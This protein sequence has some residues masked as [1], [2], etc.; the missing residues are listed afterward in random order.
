MS[1]LVFPKGF[2]WGAAVSAYQTEGG[3]SNSDW[4]DWEL[5]PGSPAREPSGTAIEHYTRYARDVALLGEL[6]LN[7]YRFGFEWSR[8]EPE[9]GRF[10][11]RVLDHYRRMVAAVRRNRLEPL[12][13]LFHFTL[14]KWLAA[15]G[16]WLSDRTPAL[17]E[18]YVRRVAEAMGDRVDWYMTINEPGVVSSGGYLGALPFPPGIGGVGNWR[19][20]IDE[21]I[22]AHRRG[23]AAIKEIRPRARVGMAHSM[24]EWES[25]W[26]GRPAMEYARRYNEDVYLEACVDD[27]YV[28]INTYTGE[29]IDLP[30]PVGLLARVALAWGPLERRVVPRI[31]ASIR[32]QTEPEALMKRG[33]RRTQMG[34][35]WRPAAVATTVRRVAA[36]HPGKPLLVTEHGVATT[37]DE[38]RIEYIRDGLVA[39]HRVIEEGIPLRGYIHW[40]AFDNFEWA[41]GYT[42]KFGLVEVDRKTQERRIRPSARYL[43][44]IARANALKVDDGA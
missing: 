9:E 18:R 37:N 40:S 16:G 11:E 4:W 17:F 8:I 13:T 1:E 12:V 10:D 28:G 42:M 14:P 36:M 39:L 19:R 31:A 15:Q 35:E 6:G 38:E 7:T 2:M 23:R 25:N 20:S 34:W 41:S 21:L 44:R 33:G 32:A 27:D 43:G 26:G 5:Q 3:N 24:Q 30:V 22:E 29:R